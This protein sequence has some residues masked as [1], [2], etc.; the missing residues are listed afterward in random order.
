MHIVGAKK[1]RLIGEDDDDALSTQSDPVNRDAPSQEPDTAATSAPGAMQYPLR[2]DLG[3]SGMQH[4]S[5]T[6]I[7]GLTSRSEL[8]YPEA[9]KPIAREYWQKLTDAKR[10]EL[11][12]K[13]VSILEKVSFREERT[14]HIA[15]NSAE[16]L[17]EDAVVRRHMAMRRRRKKRGYEGKKQEEEERR[18]AP[19][20]RRYIAR[21][22]AFDSSPFVRTS[23]LEAPVF[24]PGMVRIKRGRDKNKRRRNESM[25]K[26]TNAPSTP[27]PKL[28]VINTRGAP[29][30]GVETWNN[31]FGLKSRPMT[32]YPEA[33][34]KVPKLFWRSMSREHKE[35][36]MS[37]Q[38]VAMEKVGFEPGT[39][40]QFIQ[41]F[42]PMLENRYSN[43]P[44]EDRKADVVRPP[45]SF[46]LGIPVVI[47]GIVVS[48]S[49]MPGWVPEQYIH[50]P[51][52]PGGFVIAFG[53]L[54]ML[55]W[56][57]DRL[58]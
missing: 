32:S 12:A 55:W 56:R 51:F 8:Y 42:D 5:S 9:Y 24:I 58:R 36:V 18:R 23:P 15:T 57:Q 45:L 47:L 35:R 49:K 48:L 53:I 16:A 40:K 46:F 11:I 21:D 10:N 31:R 37:I 7:F 52:H 54:M 3:T 26:E 22:T 30:V 25:S 6:N 27:P 29:V 1:V 28:T 20:V 39:S 13:Q 38:A 2:K 43:T 34:A 50:W 14:V 41:D 19:L 44:L 17:Y 4:L 33:Y